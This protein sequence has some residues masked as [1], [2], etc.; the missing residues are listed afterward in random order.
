MSL[1]IRDRSEH[2]FELLSAGSGDDHDG[3]AVCVL[4]GGIDQQNVGYSDTARACQV[5]RPRF[6]LLGAFAVTTNPHI[7]DQFT[8]E[9]YA[10]DL[11]VVASGEPL[12][13][14]D[15]MASCLRSQ[16][17]DLRTRETEAAVQ[18]SE[19]RGLGHDLIHSHD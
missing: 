2:F 4:A 18:V 15:V 3:M 7:H 1:L 5:H 17:R 9:C 13:G 11:V 16:A 12:D 19:K 6:L 8:R 14:L 10:V